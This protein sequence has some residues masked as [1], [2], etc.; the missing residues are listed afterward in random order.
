MVLIGRYLRREIVVAV[1][2]VL[3]GFLSLFAFFDLI[4]ELEDVGRGGYRLQHAVAFVLLGLPSHVYELMPIA[5]LIGSIYALSQLAAHS[6]YTAMRASGLGRRR[7]LAVV[8]RVG[9]AMAVLTA[10]VGEVLSP[11]AERLAQQLRL[12]A[13]G[14]SVTGQFRSG[15]W[16]K[17]TARD[18]AGEVSL[19][20]F[21]NIGELMPDGT[22]RAIRIFEFDPQ[23]HLR[24]LLEARGASW[25]RDKGWRLSEVEEIRFAEIAETGAGPAVGTRRSTA[26]TLLWNTELRPDILGVLLVQPD[27]MSGFNLY[28]Y[29]RH[30]RENAQDT[31]QYEIAFWKKIVY[32]LAVIVMMA[33]ALPFAYLQVRAGGTSYKVFAGIMLGIAFHFLNGLFSH[34]G[35]LNTWPP[36]LSVSIPSVAAFMLAL[37]ML[38]WVDRA[39]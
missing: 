20:R 13:I 15:L 38:A 36:L 26:P 6:E 31:G 1:A 28:S 5:A 14:G 9:L 18:A 12:S 35:L 39:R 16:V 37:G 8:A 10:L 11:P 22:L 33:L 25:A 23:M 21:V 17:D 34:L 27:R 3:L 32:P 29:I 4:N 7:A 2:F 30:L 24:R 19:M